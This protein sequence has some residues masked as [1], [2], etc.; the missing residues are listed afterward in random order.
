MNE[1]AARGETVAVCV[2]EV[3][4]V[5]RR[6]V[7]EAW[8]EEERVREWW[9]PEGFTDPEIEIDLREG[10]AFRFAMKNA[11]GEPVV[12]VGRFLEVT[13]PERLVYTWTWEGDD[14][15]ETRVT[16]EFRETDAGTELVLVHERF[17]SEEMADLHREGWIGGL[18]RLHGVVAGG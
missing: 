18:E 3:Y 6:R 16:V 7:F 17:P 10:G 8:T 9:A 2:N 12:A 13:P 11:D 5:P 4:A 1:R 14:P 15:V